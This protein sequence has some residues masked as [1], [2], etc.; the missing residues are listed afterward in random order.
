MWQL[1]PDSSAQLSS[2][3]LTHEAQFCSKQHV[4][5][6]WWVSSQP[7]V[8]TLYVSKPPHILLV[9]DCQK[10]LYVLCVIR[11]ALCCCRI[12]SY[13]LS[14]IIESSY[15]RLLQQNSVRL[16]Y[17]RPSPSYS[18]PSAVPHKALTFRYGRTDKLANLAMLWDRKESLVFYVP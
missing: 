5:Y 11:Q 16:Q 6:T 10:R 4:C 12:I 1:S 18:T 2:A 14:I 15:W 9:T 13:C 17:D 8:N 3:H 7:R